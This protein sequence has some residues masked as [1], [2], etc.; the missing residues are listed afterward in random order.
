MSLA[1]LNREELLALIDEA[2]ERKL[3]EWLLADAEERELRPEVRER[4]LRQR[5]EVKAGARG[6]SLDDAL[7]HLSM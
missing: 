7:A 2:V 6:Y 3:A 1:G 5:A 4:L